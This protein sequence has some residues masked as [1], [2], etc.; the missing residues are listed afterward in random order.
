MGSFHRACFVVVQ[1][2]SHLQPFVTTWTAARQASLSITVC[3]SLLKFMSI[4]LVM[5]SNHLILCHY[6]LL[7]LLLFPSLGVFF[8]E[9]APRLIWPNY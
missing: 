4:K 7:L 9:L 1:S 8:N 2:L 5:L 6:L 3:W